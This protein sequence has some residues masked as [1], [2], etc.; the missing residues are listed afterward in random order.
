[1]KGKGYSKVE[2]ENGWHGK[3]I[4]EE[5]IEEL[6]GIRNLRIDVAKP[7][8]G[9]PHRF[10]TS[11]ASLAGV[12]GRQ[13]GLDPQGV[14]RG[15]RRAR[16]RGGRRR[17][18]RRRGLQL[19]VRRDLPPRRTRSGTSRC[20]S[21]SS[22]WS[23]P[24]SGCRCSVG[25]RSARRSPRSSRRAYDFVRMA[26]VSRATLGSAARTR[27]SRSARTARRRWGSR[28]SRSSARS[29]ARPCSI[30]A[31]AT[32]PLALVADDG[33]PRRHLVPADDPRRHA[34][35]LRAQTRRSRSVAPRRSAT[36]TTSRSSRP[37]SPLHEALKAAEALAEEGIAARVIDCYSVKPIDAA[38]LS[39]APHADRHGRGPLGRRRPR[40]GGALRA[41]REPAR[42]T[43]DAMLAVREL[44]HSGKPA[45]L[46][47]AAGID[48][49]HIAEA[50]RDSSSARARASRSSRSRRRR[51][52]KTAPSTT[53][54]G[55]PG[56]LKTR[57]RGT[58]DGSVPTSRRLRAASVTGRAVRQRRRRPGARSRPR[59]ASGRRRPALTRKS[60]PSSATTSADSP[61][62]TAP[63]SSAVLRQVEA[64]SLPS[65][66][67]PRSTHSTASSTSPST[68]SLA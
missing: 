45:E 28:T 26:A 1:M 18:P 24:R 39:A 65:A 66:S 21:R 61:W 4:A 20:T 31:T 56:A 59:A 38:T 57:Y 53:P 46:L 52:P 33:R 37:A 44:P 36:A 67:E 35:R 49:D 15:P 58:R 5:A 14:R 34:G 6:G 47:A 19:D 48:A 32:R 23:R 3:A 60:A 55:T 12:R 42:G 29:T 68:W 17:R 40:R 54:R 25:S 11:T 64:E 62:T 9:S 7:E 16:R 50:A 41:R 13:R 30:R 2:N 8:P 63:T 10:E 43:R 27:A 51:R 22:R